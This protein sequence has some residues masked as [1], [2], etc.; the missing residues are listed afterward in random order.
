MEGWRR[1]RKT[2]RLELEELGGG[3]GGREKGLQIEGL[4]LDG[5][6]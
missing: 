1:G 5:G 4:S 2:S 3:E 6:L